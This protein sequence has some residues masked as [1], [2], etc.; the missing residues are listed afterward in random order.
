LVSILEKVRER[1]PHVLFVM[2]PAQGSTRQK[3]REYDIF[4]STDF[5]RFRTEFKNLFGY[6]PG[7]LR[8][9]LKYI[10]PKEVDVVLDASGFA[11]GDTWGA[12]YVKSLLTS[13]ISE[14]KEEG[15]T[16]ILLP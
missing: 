7:S 5:R 12:Q 10:T 11:Y 15:K 9:R 6:V 16:V 14:W 13:H 8:R 4:H 3:L 2:G 1:Y